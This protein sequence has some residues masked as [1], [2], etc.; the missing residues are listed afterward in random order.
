MAEQTRK[1]RKPV[2]AA[3]EPERL[4]AELYYMAADIVVLSPK[5][6]E[7]LRS[8]AAKIEDDL[9]VRQRRRSSGA[10]D[11]KSEHLRLVV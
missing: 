8:A 6:A 2:T 4:P 9:R 10:E 1:A 3:A 11:L 7:L 5:A